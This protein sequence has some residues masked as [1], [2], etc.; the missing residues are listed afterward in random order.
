MSVSTTRT[1]TI[2]LL[3]AATVS[4]LIVGGGGATAAPIVA[5][6]DAAAAAAPSDP[7][8][9]GDYLPDVSG[10]GTVLPSEL[11]EDTRLFVN[12]YRSYL[13]QTVDGRKTLVLSTGFASCYFMTQD[14]MRQYPC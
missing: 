9:S 3:T 13:V 6:G 8:S 12:P 2:V 5:A 4:G 14:G 1:R 11:T 7:S 10:G